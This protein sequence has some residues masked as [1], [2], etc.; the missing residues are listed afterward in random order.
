MLS[1]T[2]LSNLKES[3]VKFPLPQQL[4][5]VYEAKNYLITSETLK[6]SLKI[7]LTVSELHWAVEYQRAKPLL[8]FIELSNLFLEK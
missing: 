7:G 3:G 6:H 5:L 8:K 4:T 1:E 2:M